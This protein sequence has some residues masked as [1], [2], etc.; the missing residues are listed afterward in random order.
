PAASL[1]INRRLYKSCQAV[2]LSRAAG[3]RHSVC[4][5]AAPCVV[6]P[7][8][9]LRVADIPPYAEYVV[10][11]H[12]YAILANVRLD[13][14]TY[15]TVLA[16]PLLVS[17]VY[18]ILTLPAFLHRRAQ[19]LSA[20]AYSPTPPSSAS[21]RPPAP[22][23]PPLA[24]PITPPMLLSPTCSTCSLPLARRRDRRAARAARVLGFRRRGAWWASASAPPP[25]ACGPS[26]SRPSRSAGR[27]TFFVFAAE[28]HSVVRAPFPIPWT[29]AS[30]SARS[31]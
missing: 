19:F 3:A 24:S 1:C 9:A 4:A 14:T 16:Y 15:D 30:A 5:D 22:P 2:S 17:A 6:L 11:G 31:R 23:H 12:R 13:P 25:S 8:L 26:P 21:S 18:C 29:K 20:P 7:S 27:L 10:Q 28:V